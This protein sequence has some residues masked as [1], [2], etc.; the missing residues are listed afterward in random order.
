[1]IMIRIVAYVLVA[2]ATPWLLQGRPI[3]ICLQAFCL[4]AM[5]ARQLL[6]YSRRN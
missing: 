6:T 2:A 4:G 5:A 3:L 1:M